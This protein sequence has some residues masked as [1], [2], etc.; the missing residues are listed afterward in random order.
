MR[1]IGPLR[2]ACKARLEGRGPRGVVNNRGR[3]MQLDTDLNQPPPFAG[4]NLFDTDASLQDALRAAGV[5]A[6]REKLSALGADYG[7][8]ET[9]DLGRLA[10]ENPPKLK[11]FDA[12]GAPLNIVEFHPAYHALMNKSMA[13]GL[14]SSPWE[15]AVGPQ[16]QSARAARLYIAQQAEPGHI[17][18]LTMT[19]ASV[20]ALSASP[21]ILK[22]WL[23]KIR[24]R[25]YDALFKPWREKKSC[26]LGMGMTERQGGSDVRANVTQAARHGDHYEIDGHKWFMSAPMCDAFLVLAQAQGGLTC[27]LMPRFTPEGAVNGLMFQ[28]LKDKLG[29]RSNASSEVEFHKAYAGRVGDEGAGVRT[30]LGMVQLTRLDCAAASAGLMRSCLAQAAHH[31]RHRSAFQRML[32]GQPQMRALLADLALQSEAATAAAF[33]LVSANERGA[34][35]P[36]AAAYARLLAPALKYFIC[37]ITPGFVFECLEVLGGNGYVEDSPLARAYREAPLNSIWEGSG[38]VIALDVLRAAQRA[39]EA[40]AEVIKRL[41]AAAGPHGAEAARGLMGLLRGADAERHARKIAETLAH[42][43]GA[44]ALGAVQPEL[45]ARY[46]ATRLGG[47]H[48]ATWGACDLA[49]VES[50]LID[51]VAG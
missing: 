8:A 17:C 6:A 23:P 14:H 24:S 30:I 39:P 22:D 9:L 5:D 13:A 40:A 4:I 15:A 35:D 42:L 28:R 47:A 7:S 21:E 11:R 50:V 3:M 43:A 46:A 26:A 29:N 49:G 16:A 19:H 37:K 34:G 1:S 33:A 45:A 10:N 31:A 44:A 18:P 12:R 36:Q 48:R 25:E 2:S 32:I 41:G 27:F 51:R 20:A 38:N